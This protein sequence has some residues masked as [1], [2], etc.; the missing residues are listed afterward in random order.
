MQQRT[1]GLLRIY[2][3]E[4][5]AELSGLERAVREEKSHRDRNKMWTEKIKWI[6]YRDHT[7]AES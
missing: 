6:E 5:W 7:M 3:K 2:T 1:R 4:W